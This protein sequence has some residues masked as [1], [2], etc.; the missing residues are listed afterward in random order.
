MKATI[1]H[2]FPLAAGLLMIAIACN[3][4]VKDGGNS[5]ESTA[6]ENTSSS[7]SIQ[8][9]Q[10]GEL[11]FYDAATLP[12]SETFKKLQELVY[13]DAPKQIT[14]GESYDVVTKLYPL[15]WSTDGKMAYAEYSILYEGEH[16]LSYT[17]QDM[18]TGDTLVSE[19][20]AFGMEASENAEAFYKDNGYLES[21]VESTHVI[22]VK[23]GESEKALFQYVWTLCE[24]EILEA[25]KKTGITFDPSASFIA[26]ASYPD[27]SFIV[28]EQNLSEDEYQYTLKSNKYPSK[29][30][31]QDFFPAPTEVVGIINSPFSKNI[32]VICRQKRQG[33]EMSNDVVA[34]L[35]GYPL[36]G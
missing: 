36:G 33:F 23:E 2:L 4:S 18:N 14:E 26:P 35:V 1:K 16:L 21:D 31:Y 24:Q 6:V 30:I 15:G 20:L 19:S 9:E 28:E 17:I 27:A 32:V 7:T 11:T 34:V 29:V 12:E 22:L 5:T 8:G 25:L 13:Y 10:I 3:P